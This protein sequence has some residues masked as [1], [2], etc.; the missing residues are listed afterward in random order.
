MKLER[1]SKTFEYNPQYDPKWNNTVAY[2]QYYKSVHSHQNICG[3]ITF[4]NV[5]VKTTHILQEA[6]TSW[7]YSAVRREL[8]ARRPRNKTNI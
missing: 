7:S 6:C 2:A 1:F 3:E 4:I 5:W 8:P